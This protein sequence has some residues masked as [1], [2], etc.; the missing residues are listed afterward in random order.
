MTWNTDNS[1]I[2]AINGSYV[3]TGTSTRYLPLTGTTTESSSSI[4]ADVTLIG[5]GKTSLLLSV[6]FM[7]DSVMGLTAFTLREAGSLIATKTVNINTADIVYRVDFTNGTDSSSDTNEFT[8][9]VSIGVN[10]T[11]AGST[12]LFSV[13]FERGLF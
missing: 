4:N 7:T 2:V 10:P 11:T 12:N 1:E 6:N 13:V 3:Y 9:D 5:N 8:G